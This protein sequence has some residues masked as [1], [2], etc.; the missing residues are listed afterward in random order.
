MIFLILTTRSN[1]FCKNFE[2]TESI[3]NIFD[4]YFQDIFYGLLVMNWI[5]GGM[6]FIIARAIM[7]KTYNE[8]KKVQF[9]TLSPGGAFSTCQFS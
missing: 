3:L 7:I 5:F 9:I 6:M 2:H 4:G 1:S 8:E